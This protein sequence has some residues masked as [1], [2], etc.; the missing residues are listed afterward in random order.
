MTF[1]H[2]SSGYITPYLNGVQDG[3]KTY[4]GTVSAPSIKTMIGAYLNVD[5][6]DYF[7]NGKIYSIFGYN[8]ALTAAEV[9]Q[10]YS[11]VTRLGPATISLAINGNPSS[12]VYRSNAQIRLTSN[13]P[14]K[15]IFFQNGKRI[16][17]CINI[18][19]VDT[20]TTANC[21]WRPTIHGTTQL[22]ATITP[23]NASYDP[24]TTYFKISA[25][26]RTTKR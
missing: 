7:F 26:A 12:V 19:L 18:A 5:T 10:N 25:D 1:V 20:A 3:A 21:S 23:T 8:K 9:A 15:V 2:D 17:G 6:P 22:S 24:T 11:A 4:F 13:Q 16:S 14:G